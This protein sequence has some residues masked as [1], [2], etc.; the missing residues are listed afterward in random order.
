MDTTGKLTGA[1][2]TFNGQGIILTFEVDASAAKQIEH[3]KPDDLLQI[4][5]VK[6]RQKR[7]IDAN[8][9]AWVLMTNIAN[10]K[11]IYS[12]KDEVYEEMLQKYGAFYE[13]EDG[14]ITITVKKSVD[15]SR[16]M[17]IGNILKTM[18]NLLRI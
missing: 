5:A 10:S 16:L 15:M 1:I 12:S 13:D 9:Y 3:L 4:K 18:G 11:D 2:R 6:Y 8:A 17:V 7:S 14:Y